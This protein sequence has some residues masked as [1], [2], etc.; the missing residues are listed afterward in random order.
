[1]GK[2]SCEAITIGMAHFVFIQLNLQN[3]LNQNFTLLLFPH[4]NISHTCFLQLSVN[5]IEK[6]DKIIAIS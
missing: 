4:E 2:T 6:L 5:I 3:E 1:L